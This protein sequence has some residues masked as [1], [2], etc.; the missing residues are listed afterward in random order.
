MSKNIK[1]VIPKWRFPKFYPMNGWNEKRIGQLLRIGNGRDYKHLLKGN[2]PVYGS[3]GYMLSVN[4]YLH[5]GDS[6]CIGRKGTINNPLFIRG[7]FWAVDTL[8]Y[9]HSYKE[10]IPSFI[11][12]IFQKIDWLKYSEA[13][14]VPSLSKTTI[15]KI[16]IFL[17]QEEEQQKI[18]DCLSSID[19]LISAEEKKLSLLQNYKKGWMQ[20]LFPAEGKTIP[21]WRFPEFKDSGEWETIKLRE[22]ADYRRGSFPQ[23]YGLPKWYDELSGMPFIQVFDV[24]EN[25]CLK[26]TTK[27][28]ISELA[29]QQS[30]FIEKGTLIVTLQG[31]IG[32]VAITQYDAYIDRTLLLFEKFYRDVDKV[33]LAHTIQ[34]LFEIKKQSAPG[35]IIKTI[36]KQ[37]LSE[38]TVQLPEKPEQQKIANFLSGIDDLISKQT[39]KI[40]ALKHHKKALMQGLFPTVEEI[41]K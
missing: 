25:M 39:G 13:S 24:D 32:R 23:P 1:G 17:P 5:D 14:G 34:Q 37:V 28:K 8:F 7:K 3:G 6:V 36:T 15:E 30:V 26:A 29:S 27:N 19:E 35:G 40:E 41:L 20:K 38:F 33:F 16:N 18:A 2:I 31:S 11:Y 4:D 9:T 21:E 10:C 22:L 12:N